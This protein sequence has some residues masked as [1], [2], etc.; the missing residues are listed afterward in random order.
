VNVL[1]I[2]S[3]AVHASYQMCTCTVTFITVLV[4][5]VVLF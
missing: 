3:S 2:K 1:S 4:F 5:A